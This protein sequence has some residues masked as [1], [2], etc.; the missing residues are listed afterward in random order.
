[1]V[2]GLV[3]G[4]GGGGGGGDDTDVFHVETTR[5]ATRARKGHT[6]SEGRA[7]NFLAATARTVTVFMS[8]TNNRG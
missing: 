6:L 2:G 7:N 1:V 5:I 8:A 4:W 3:G